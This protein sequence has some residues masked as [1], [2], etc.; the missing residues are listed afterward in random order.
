[1]IRLKPLTLGP[2][3]KCYTTVALAMTDAFPTIIVKLFFQKYKIMTQLSCEN[4][5]TI[6]IEWK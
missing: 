1:M 6:N 3:G 4:K 5:S 2:W